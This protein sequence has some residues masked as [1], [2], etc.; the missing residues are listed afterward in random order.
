[1]TAPA[2]PSAIV[3]PISSQ[4]MCV[5]GASCGGTSEYALVLSPLQCAIP[6]NTSEPIPAEISPG[7]RMRGSIG[8]P[9]TARLDHEN[10]RD[11]GRTE[12][13]RYRGEAPRRRHDH[14]Q[15]RRRVAL[16]ELHRYDGEPGADRD[17]RRLGAEHD[18][19]TERRQR[20]ERDAGQHVRIVAADHLQSVRGHVTAVA[21]KAHD[22]EGDGQPGEA[23]HDQ[24][25]PRRHRRVAHVGRQIG[26]HPDLDAMHQ[27][28][29][30]PTRERDDHPDDR[31]EHEQHHEVAAPQY[32]RGIR[33]GRRSG[34]VFSHRRPAVAPTRETDTGGPYDAASSRTNIAP[35][36]PAQ[37]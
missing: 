37:A 19:E 22:R 28:Q 23:Q 13:H 34:R 18:A 36:R 24:V 17:Q 15:L 29:E 2:S 27:L 7:M 14:E 8:P 30:A 32:R 4:V 21:G 20:G 5:N 35:S 11:D 6:M 31:R 10:G 25:P 16:R 1:M 33:P 26:E 12:D 3:Q 9:E